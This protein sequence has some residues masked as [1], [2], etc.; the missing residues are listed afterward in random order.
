M[1]HSRLAMHTVVVCDLLTGLST[2]IRNG[3]KTWNLSEERSRP[4]TC[5]G[6]RFS[7]CNIDAVSVTDAV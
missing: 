3:S 4:S 7:V 5:R 2:S 6:G 1:I